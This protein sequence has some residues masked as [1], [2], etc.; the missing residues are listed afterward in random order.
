MELTL[1]QIFA[2]Y[3]YLFLAAFVFGGICGV[4]VSGLLFANKMDEFITEKLQDSC[5]W[6]Q[7]KDMSKSPTDVTIDIK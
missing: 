5:K 2:A 4:V 7:P 3:W 1:M 6:N